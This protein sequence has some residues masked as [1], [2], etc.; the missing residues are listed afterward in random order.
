VYSP[1]LPSY[2][3]ATILEI[4]V[5]FRHS[6]G[7]LGE[8]IPFLNPI[9][10]QLSPSFCNNEIT[11]SASKGASPTPLYIGYIPLCI[12]HPVQYLLRNNSLSKLLK[13][14]SDRFNDRLRK[15][16]YPGSLTIKTMAVQ[17]NLDF[18]AYSL[19]PV[20]ILRHREIDLI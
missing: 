17:V 1:Y 12:G 15:E 14:W 7:E 2:P 18:D 3:A 11:G 20:E 4:L 16:N 13:I 5:K 6:T 8:N 9:I 10:L 19:E